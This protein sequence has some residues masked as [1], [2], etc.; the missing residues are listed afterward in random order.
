MNA[1]I[2]GRHCLLKNKPHY[3]HVAL[4]CWRILEKGKKDDICCKMSKIDK[5]LIFVQNVF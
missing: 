3:L 4:R 1:W 2:E 5:N